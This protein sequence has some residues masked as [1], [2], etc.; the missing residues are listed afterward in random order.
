LA[1]LQIAPSLVQK[2]LAQFEPNYLRGFNLPFRKEFSGFNPKLFRW[3]GY[4]GGA[5]PWEAKPLIRVFPLLN[6][7]FGNFFI[8]NQ[9]T[10][11]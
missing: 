5:N 10:L 9:F 4:E 6:A 8:Q 3:E 11:G 7:S 1:I 2:N